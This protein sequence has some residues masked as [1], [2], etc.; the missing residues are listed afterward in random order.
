[1]TDAAKGFPAKARR[2]TI[3][4]DRI[5]WNSLGVAVSMKLEEMRNAPT[6]KAQILAAAAAQVNVTEAAITL[7]RSGRRL[8]YANL[9]RLC[10]LTGQRPEFYLIDDDKQ[11]AREYFAARVE[12]GK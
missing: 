2:E 4:L 3:D 8:S 10:E 6:I 1:M 9:H 7:S 5:N 12:G 11:A